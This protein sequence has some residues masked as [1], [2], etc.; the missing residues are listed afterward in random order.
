MFNIWKMSEEE[1]IQ[2]LKEMER[3]IRMQ[4]FISHMKECEK[5]LHSAVM[6]MEKR[7]EEMR[8]SPDDSI[9]YLNEL[10]YK[11]RKNRFFPFY[12]KSWIAL[13]NAIKELEKHRR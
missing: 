1:M 6:I 7:P 3:H 4:G 2:Y 12:D 5:A 13:K 8:L 9:R 11:T 10:L